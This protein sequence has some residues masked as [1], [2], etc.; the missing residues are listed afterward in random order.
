[1]VAQ[2]RKSGITF[3]PEAAT[4]RMRA[5]INKWIPDEEL[6]T[7]SE[8]TYAGGWDVV[9]LYFM[10]G[11]PTEREE[12]VDAIADLARRT[13][14]VGKAV[15]PRA[16]LNLGVSTFVPRPFTPF[17]W[18][19]QITM[20]QAH[21]RQQQ[22]AER[23]GRSPDIKFGKH[24]P[25]ESF[26]EGILSR[27][28]RRAADLIEAAF[29][30]GCRFD[31]WREHQNID[32]WYAAIEETE[33]DVDWALGARE[34]GCRL[35][36]DHIDILM[37]KA[38]MEEDYKRAVDLQHAPDCRAGKCHK[39]GVI[40]KER[41]LCA[42]M[43]KDHINARKLDEQVPLPVP[44]DHTEEPVQRIWFKIGRFDQARL[45][46][47]LEGMNAW[48]RALRR[49]GARLAYS[50]GFSPHAK[51]AFSGATPHGHESVGDYME[52]RLVERTD[53]QDLLVR[54][55]E[56][57]PPGFEVIDANEVAMNAPS[58][59]SMNAGGDYQMTVPESDWDGLEDR[60]T[61]VLTAT[62]LPVQRRAKKKKKKKYR[63]KWTSNEPVYKT[64]DIRPMIHSID[65]VGPGTLSTRLVNDGERGLK[66]RELLSFLVKDPE[67]VRV[68]RL[69]TLRIEGDSWV[70]ISD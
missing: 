48:L 9:K 19:A 26:L 7:M 8:G 65:V 15:N 4:P 24:S 17:Q 35:P 18:A 2:G 21:A 63:G 5:V 38:W 57:L 55:R 36:W 31:G 47:H 58:L 42:S 34:V 53:P 12:D 45:L 52:I 23:L 64:I 13:L 20:D 50:K 11:L 39:C 70:P 69:E 56:R 27:S 32:G 51:V 28:D 3:A 22:L 66:A 16:R 46:S 33:F 29:R 41:E 6:L 59:M 54:L 67:R 62:E 61:M 10:I 43:L 44:P 25:K 68:K 14:A 1:M 37:D 49:S 60:I 30:N 40:D